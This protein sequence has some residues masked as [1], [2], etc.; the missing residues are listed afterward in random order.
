ML[1]ESGTFEAIDGNIQVIGRNF[2]VVLKKPGIIGTILGSL[3]HTSSNFLLVHF[4]D[5]HMIFVQRAD[6][7]HQPIRLS[8]Q[9]V[10]REA[11]TQDGQSVN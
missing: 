8:Q 11:K 9:Q 3:L 7:I 2:K 6:G 4:F 5:Q 1:S 10:G